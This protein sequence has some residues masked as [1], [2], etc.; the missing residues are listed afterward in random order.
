MCDCLTDKNYTTSN[1]KRYAAFIF[2]IVFIFATVFSV[3]YIAEEINHDCTGNDCPICECVHQA[4]QT[5]KNIG[6]GFAEAVIIVAAVV[7]LISLLLSFG[8]DLRNSSLISQKVRM[9]C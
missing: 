7:V 9:D 8:D 1:A 6:T 5:L 4:Q 3:F 2:S